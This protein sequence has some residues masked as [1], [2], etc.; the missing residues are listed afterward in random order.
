M[1]L[2]PIVRQH[3]P[4]LAQQGN[5]ALMLFLSLWLRSVL[6]WNAYERYNKSEPLHTSSTTGESSL[7][8]W[9]SRHLTFSPTC[10]LSS[11]SCKVFPES[12]FTVSL[13]RFLQLLCEGHNQGWYHPVQPARTA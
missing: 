3:W 6:N 2:D 5:S 11:V 7:P 4:L 10:L 12:A 13:F 8:D 9:G 1:L